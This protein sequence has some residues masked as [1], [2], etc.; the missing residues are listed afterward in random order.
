[1]KTTLISLVFGLMIALEASA[2]TEKG[3]W[4]VGAQVGNFTYQKEELDY[5]NI[6]GSLTPSAGCF[7]NNGLVIGTGIPFS[8][9][10]TKFGQLFGNYDNLRQVG[11]SI[12]L[13]PF[14][15]YYVGSAKLK[16]FVGIA[17]RL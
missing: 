5:R 12:G 13:S 14:L 9:S 11:T 2:Q 6:S 15:R 7:I 3:R 1:M 16:P 4:T 8:F 10:S 17:Y